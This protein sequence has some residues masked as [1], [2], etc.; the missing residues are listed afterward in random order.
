MKKTADLVEKSLQKFYGTILPEIFALL[1]VGVFLLYWAIVNQMPSGYAG[2]YSLMTEKLI[3]NGFRVPGYIP[4]YGP[5]GIPFAYPPLGFYINAVMITLLKIDQFTYLRFFP[6][7]L[8]VCTSMVCYWLIR[9]MT[10]S[11]M[12]AILASI[13]FITSAEFIN[14]HITADGMV[15]GPAIFFMLLGLF[16]YW[17]LLYSEKTIYAYLLM[18]GVCL[19][20]SALAHLAYAEFMAVSVVILLL[21][22]KKK[23]QTRLIEA[24]LIGVIGVLISAP[25]WL[26]VLKNFG[27]QPLL[28][29]INSHSTIPDLSL[30]DPNS[31]SM[32]LPRFVWNLF[33]Q[34]F[35]YLAG[36]PY[37]LIKRD[38]QKA[39]W[40]GFTAAFLG[41]SARFLSLLGSTAMA[42]LFVFVVL[43]TQTSLNRKIMPSVIAVVIML[44][45][46]LVP[47]F[48]EIVKQTPSLTSDTLTMAAW[49][50][51]NTPKDS[52]YLFISGEMNGANE[53]L[54]YLAQRTPT[55]G[56]WGAEWLGD[57]Y[58]KHELISKIVQCANKEAWD[59]IQ[60]IS[61]KYT[62]KPDY[63]VFFRKDFQSLE[64]KVSAAGEWKS[65]FQNDTIMV[66]KNLR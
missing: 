65:A 34:P 11:R 38:W 12:V 50:R 39:I 25:W 33:E 30:T 27:L 4:F 54:P 1:I 18:S 52:T 42:D 49:L 59:C 20:L 24:A 62:S 47:R 13:L 5:G 56:H 43:K 15:R 37:W 16:F 36:I 66:Y 63:I 32:G 9:E 28:S 10:K 55:I 19:G 26:F 48:I 35:F 60:R 44:A 14:P 8:A 29:A 7:L 2:L 21:N 61:Q 45:L 41:E 31:P 17:K 57:Y 53:W 22:G 58:K 40:L 51:Q 23:I 3:A 46:L 6:P 64:Q